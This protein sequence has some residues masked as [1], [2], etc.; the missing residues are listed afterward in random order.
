MVQGRDFAR[1]VDYSNAELPVSRLRVVSY[2]EA[3]V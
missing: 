2:E 1:H 3:G